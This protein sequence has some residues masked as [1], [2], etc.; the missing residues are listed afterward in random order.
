MNILF[1]CGTLE[2]GK[3]GVGDYTRRF[4]AE[5]IRQGHNVKIIALY[6]KF[7][8]GCS[9]SYQKVDGIDVEVLRIGNDL[10][11]RSRFAKCKQAIE[12]FNPEL[13]SLQYVV[14]S[15]QK[16]GLPWQLTEK[17]AKL[18]SGR[19]WHLM[20]H[21]LWVGMDKEDQLKEKI[22]GTLQKQ[23][24]KKLVR[25]LSPKIIHTQI[26]LY[27]N[28]LSRMKCTVELLPLFGNIEIQKNNSPIETSNLEIAIFGGLH[29][30]AQLE[31]FVDWLTL[32]QASEPSFH[33]IGGNGEEQKNWIQIL[34][35]KNVR[36]E[37]HGWLPDSE[38]SDL[39]S[40]C[41]LSLT[42]T[43][44]HLVRK[45]GSV[46]TMLE[47]GIRVICI[48]RDWKPRQVCIEELTKNEDVIEWNPSLSID[49]LR[50]SGKRKIKGGAQEVV[51]QF[52]KQLKDHGNIE[53]SLE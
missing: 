12:E 42:S 23:I 26:P 8:K 9:H 30:G 53:L 5:L 48:A 16:R 44:Y 46:V 45:S 34:E 4:G 35:E 17:L 50:T 11:N 39:L 14:F 33:F 38:V 3:D 1:I 49:A 7:L 43:P 36:Y 6:D 41:N 25:R 21:E 15:F 18:G 22:W 31:S 47:H 24:I 28:L 32:K 2:P 19:N 13:L 10:L 27:Q 40:R 20:F 51:H 52:L 29:Y 37:I